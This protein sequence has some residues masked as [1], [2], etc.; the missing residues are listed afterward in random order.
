MIILRCKFLCV[1][2]QIEIMAVSYS[3]TILRI[4]PNRSGHDLEILKNDP[5]FDLKKHSKNKKSLSHF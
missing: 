2:S 4:T 3:E 5:K 1:I